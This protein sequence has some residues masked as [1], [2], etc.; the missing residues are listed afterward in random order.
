VN[1]L[2][3][4]EARSQLSVF[5]RNHP[6]VPMIFTTRELSLGGDLGIE[7]KLEMQ[8]LTEVQMQAFVRAYVPEQA[9]KMLR[10]LKER[11]REFGQTPLLL[12]MLCEVF[13]QSPDKQLPSN[14][15][16]VFQKFTQMYEISSVRK[17]EVA[18]LKGD[19]RPLSDRRLWKKALKTIA[20]VMMQGETPVDF[21]VAIHRDEAEK[22]LNKIFA[23]EVFPT[24][25]ILD[26]LLKYHLLQNRSSDQIEFRHQLLQ[27]YYAAEA[28]SE[29]LTTLDHEQL[30]QTYLN[31]LKW[32]EPF[33]LLMGLL[34]DTELV[35]RITKLALNIDLM[36]AVKLINATYLEAHTYLVKILKEINT[37]CKTKD[38]ILGMV[39]HNHRREEDIFDFL[40]D[41]QQKESNITFENLI[42]SLES[43]KYHYR[44]SIIIDLSNYFPEKAIQILEDSFKEETSEEV[45]SVIVS[46]LA[47][48]SGLNSI[49]LIEQALSD[50][51]GLV[52]INAAK[53][54]GILKYSS[55]SSKLIEMIRDENPYVC[56]AA[57]KSLIS[58]GETGSV[59]NILDFISELDNG[60]KDLNDFSRFWANQRVVAIIDGLKEASH[61]VHQDMIRRL[62]NIG[63]KE[64]LRSSL[65]EL[66]LAIEKSPE[67]WTSTVEALAS[68]GSE[69]AKQVILEMLEDYI[70]FLEDSS[71]DSNLLV[72]VLQ[73]IGTINITSA[74]PSLRK[75]IRLNSWLSEHA[76]DALSRL[77]DYSSLVCLTQLWHSSGN[78]QYLQAIFRLQKNCKYYNYTIYQAY[79][80]AQKRDRSE[81]HT[82][83]SQPGNVTMNF[84]G[85]VYGAAGNIQRDQNINPTE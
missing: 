14:L 80:E 43:P 62:K 40:G 46:C 66:Q 38:L 22:E 75:L 55:I 44:E 71:V 52:R 18:L 4:E 45:R 49:R 72:T 41:F 20:L 32:T 7:K 17:H 25:D 70:D 24:R 11:L 51:G 5:R 31:F 28:L 67:K 39:N 23:R 69:N 21:R 50:P 78:T 82:S 48:T 74:I 27:E 37:P 19:V 33:R 35:L 13:Q 58:L 10:E 3:S 79:L 9:E 36:L 65:E 63:E 53:A 84:Y 56:G 12:W 54:I 77:N 6:K 64:E 30:K 60:Y 8:P 83:D 76:A 57:V 29:Q 59:G 2:P 1:E 47:R 85:T 42:N 16:G 61:E 68:I 73:I 15:A 34:E 81:G 26:D